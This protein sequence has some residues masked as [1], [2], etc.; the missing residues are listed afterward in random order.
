MLKSFEIKVSYLSNKNNE[1]SN[2][3][4]AKKSGVECSNS[5]L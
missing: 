5:A 3:V 1:S 2:S 4:F